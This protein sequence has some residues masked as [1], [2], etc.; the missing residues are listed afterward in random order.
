[1]HMNDLTKLTISQA[2][3][4]LISKEITSKELVQAHI[5]SIEKNKHL[6]AFITTTPELALKAAEESDKKIQSG[7]YGILEGIPIANKDLY[8]TKNV[9]TTAGS[10]SLEN[11]IPPYESTVTQNLKDAGSIYFYSC[12]WEI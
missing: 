6:N 11:F 4:K 12:Y 8:C 5:E 9:R 2:R 10:K 7:D 1:M 3:D